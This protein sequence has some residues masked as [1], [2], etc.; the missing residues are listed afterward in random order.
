MNIETKE[1]KNLK[2]KKSVTHN[3]HHL[4]I[5]LQDC[6]ISCEMGPLTDSI[7]VCLNSIT[8]CLKSTKFS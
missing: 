5:A 2:L 4:N 3:I 6:Q 7:T 1:L 8:A